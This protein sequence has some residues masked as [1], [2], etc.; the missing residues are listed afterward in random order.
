MALGMTL[1]NAVNIC[2]RAVGESPVSSEDSQHPYVIAAKNIIDDKNR[3]IQSKGW[4]FNTQK[5]LSLPRDINKNIFIPTNT[6]ALDTNDA[7]GS[8]TVRGDKLYDTINHTF[9]FESNIVVN[10]I[11]E[12]A[13]EDLP[14]VAA[15]YIAY[16]SAEEMQSSYE[17]DQVKVGVLQAK[18]QEAKIELKKVQLRNEN[19]NSLNT[20][21]SQKLLSAMTHG[22]GRNPNFIG[23]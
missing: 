9:E 6:L 15:K 4:F 19:N 18:L 12:L 10:L 13:F 20:T 1:L 16:A 8:I 5:N 7:A 17:V 23:G 3:D 22:N 2:L 14:Y 21:Q 11:E